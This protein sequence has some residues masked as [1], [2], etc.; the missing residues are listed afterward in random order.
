MKNLKYLIL[1]FTMTLLFGCAFGDG[2]KTQAENNVIYV[3]E[4]TCEQTH[5]NVFVDDVI[6]LEDIGVKFKPSNATVKPNFSLSNSNVAVIE[7][8]IIKFLN[9]V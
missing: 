8:N 3:S 1:V 4:I 9:E 6:K 5:F 7:N 2:S